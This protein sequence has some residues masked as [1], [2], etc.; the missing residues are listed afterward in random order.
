MKKIFNLLLVA[1][2]VLMQASVMAAAN[3][4]LI[5]PTKTTFGW[6]VYTDKDTSTKLDTTSHGQLVLNYKF[7][8][9]EWIALVREETFGLTAMDGIKFHF[10]A[11]GSV[12]NFEFK[13]T[14]SK[15]N[16]FGYRILSGTHA[17]KWATVVIP[18]KAFEYF[19]G[20]DGKIDWSSLVKFELT[21]DKGEPAGNYVLNT[22]K[23][24]KLEISDVQIV[25]A[26]NVVAPGSLRIGKKQRDGSYE[27]DPMTG[28]GWSGYA[29]QDGECKVKGVKIFVKGKRK[30][31]I[32]ALKANYTFSKDGMWVAITKEIMID[33]NKMKLVMFHYKGNG[34]E[35]KLVFKLVDDRGRVFGYDI[36]TSVDMKKW[37]KVIIPVHKMKYLYGGPGAGAPNWSYVKKIEFT[38]EK[39]DASKPSGTLYLSALK[40]RM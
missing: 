8:D 3:G 33:L 27:I 39:K 2:F 24:G 34:G 28:E 37:K 36:D 25:T 12:L 32:N 14:D 17:P 18:R 29:D 4:K 9:C 16:V 23:P 26:A 10:K 20:G 22:K 11:T 15:G 5:G 19:Y 21:M 6:A 31:S 1:G 30:V 35:Q 38:I 40:Y 13:V 7:D